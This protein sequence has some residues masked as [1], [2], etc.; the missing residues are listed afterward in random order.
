MR[1]QCLIGISAANGLASGIAEG[2]VVMVALELDSEPRV[3]HEPPDLATALNDDPRARAAFERLPFGLKRRHVVALEEAK[4]V[5]TRQRRIA[6]LVTT[7]TCQPGTTRPAA[8][9]KGERRNRSR[10]GAPK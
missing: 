6:R 9:K 4:G 8:E 5:E 2:D 10:G 3:V 7:I 1:G